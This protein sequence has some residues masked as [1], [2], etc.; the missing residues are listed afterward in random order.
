MRTSTAKS[1]GCRVRSRPR[2]IRCARPLRPRCSRSRIRVVATRMVV[3]WQMADHMRTSLVTDAL[4]MARDHGYAAPGA[5]FHSDHGTQYTS[6]A[7]TRRALDS[8]LVPSMGSIGDC[9]DNSL[10]ESFWGTMQ[11]D[12]ST[13]RSGRTAPSL[14]PQ[15]SNG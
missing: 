10:V 13:R 1:R 3:G 9:Y 5:I 12:F 14:P 11:L 4:A 7:F 15:S 8:G 6:W 2:S